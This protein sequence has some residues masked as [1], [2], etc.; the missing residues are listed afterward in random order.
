MGYSIPSRPCSP[1]SR[2]PDG[3]ECTN[4]RTTLDP[5]GFYAAVVLEAQHSALLLPPGPPPAPRAR[6]FRS[7]LTSSVAV[8]SPSRGPLRVRRATACTPLGSCLA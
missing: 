6:C 5:G 4:P 3:C 2:R 1:P 8:G 7:A